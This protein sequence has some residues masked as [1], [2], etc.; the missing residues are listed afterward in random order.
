MN[1]TLKDD[2]S[3]R[4]LVTIKWQIRGNSWEF[5]R[6]WKTT[7]SDLLLNEEWTYDLQEWNIHIECLH[8]GSANRLILFSLVPTAVARIPGL[9]I[10]DLRK[11]KLSLWSSPKTK[12]LKNGIMSWSSK[13]GHLPI[14][15]D[16][17][18]VL[19]IW[20]SNISVWI[21]PKWTPFKNTIIL[22]RKS[23]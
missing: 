22:F 3:K 21:C 1:L 23:F 16:S 6:K 15:R 12:S 11:Y 14:P 19:E 4:F 18:N 10:K 9:D 8:Q 13:N 17:R 5:D 20:I 2:N 7:S